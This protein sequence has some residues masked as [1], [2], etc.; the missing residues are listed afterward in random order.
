MACLGWLDCL[1]CLD[2]MLGWTSTRQ[3]GLAQAGS[4]QSRRVLVNSLKFDLNIMQPRQHSRKQTKYEGVQNNKCW[5]MKSFYLFGT[6]ENFHTFQH[7]WQTGYP[8]KRKQECGLAL[9][10]LERNCLLLKLRGWHG[11][12]G[13]SR[14]LLPDS[15]HGRPARVCCCSWWLQ[16]V[17]SRCC[18]LW[19]QLCK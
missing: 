15:P 12:A 9:S 13:E 3:Q 1:D 18:W 10:H 19:E 11:T 16:I 6:M 17:N 2:I 8:K 7:A 4:G 14:L 5:L